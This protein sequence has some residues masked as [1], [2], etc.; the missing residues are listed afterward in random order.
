MERFSGTDHALCIY[1]NDDLKIAARSKPV[2]FESLAT[3]NENNSKI[4]KNFEE[5][6]TTLENQIQRD[7]GDQKLLKT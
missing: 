1:K 7:Q 3:N 6:G 5:T 2:I 4:G